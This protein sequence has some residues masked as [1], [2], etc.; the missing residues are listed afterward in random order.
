MF[1]PAAFGAAASGGGAFDGCAGASA[2]ARF[3]E[4]DPRVARVHDEAQLGPPNLE[5][6]DVDVPAQQR[7]DGKR[8]ID[9]VHPGHLGALGI[10]QND[11]LQRE[12]IAAEPQPFDR[13]LPGDLRVQLLHGDPSDDLPAAVGL[14][15]GP[16]AADRQERDRQDDQ[17]RHP[18]DAQGPQKA[19]PIEICRM[20]APSLTWVFGWEAKRPKQL[21][22]TGYGPGADD[23]SRRVGGVERRQRSER[24]PARQVEPDRPDG[25]QVAQRRRR[26]PTARPEGRPPRRGRSSPDR[27]RR[28]RRP[29]G[30]RAP[31]SGPRSSP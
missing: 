23:G 9:P 25:R 20:H 13:Q 22:S 1:G 4:S 31:S 29:A 8:H 24:Q 12:P 28:S 15:E 2:R 30:C 14:G 3:D 5:P 17:D 6:P 19:S 10:A 7:P 18:G 27:R 26:P 21:S 16:E 11:A